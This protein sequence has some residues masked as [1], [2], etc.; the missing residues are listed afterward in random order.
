[1]LV[2]PDFGTRGGW[3]PGFLGL[4]EEG[5]EIPDSLVGGRRVLEPGLLGPRT[6][7]SESG[8][9]KAKGLESWVPG[10]EML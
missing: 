7:T 1:M 6:R 3:R 5:M 2:F 10:D 8:E 9:G 4:G